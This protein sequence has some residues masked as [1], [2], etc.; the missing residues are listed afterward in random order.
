MLFHHIADMLLSNVAS[1]F[2]KNKLQITEGYTRYTKWLSYTRSILKIVS[3]TVWILIGNFWIKI[4]SKT[5]LQNTHKNNTL[6]FKILVFSE[7]KKIE[8]TIFFNYKIIWGPFVCIAHFFVNLHFGPS[9][10]YYCFMFCCINI[11]LQARWL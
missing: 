2:E 7:L 1:D 10:L 5:Q 8:Y 4:Y 6:L 3:K 9:A 11:K